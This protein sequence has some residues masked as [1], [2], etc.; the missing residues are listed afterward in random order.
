MVVDYAAAYQA[1]KIVIKNQEGRKTVESSA[2]CGAIASITTFGG[3]ILLGPVGIIGSNV[4]E[5]Q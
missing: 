2:K 3:A 4:N 5:V 1:V